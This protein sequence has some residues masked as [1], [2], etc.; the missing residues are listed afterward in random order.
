MVKGMNV[1][2]SRDVGLIDSP[3]CQ[4]KEYKA[5][6]SREFS[7][8]LARGR[9]DEGIRDLVVAINSCSNFFTYTS[10]AG[11][12]HHKSFNEPFLGVGIKYTTLKVDIDRVMDWVRSE[13]EPF[14]LLIL[15]PQELP[16]YRSYIV[17]ESVYEKLFAYFYESNERITQV[18]RYACLELDK[19]GRDFASW[20]FTFCDI[21]KLEGWKRDSETVWEWHACRGRNGSDLSRELLRIRQ[22]W[23]NTFSILVKICETEMRGPTLMV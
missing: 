20:T 3:E 18:D 16:Q 22:E 5:V 1:N 4:F 2:E 6:Y 11:H 15:H 13:C 8:E 12:V 17:G 9:I 21:K 19:I 14:N 23:R 7:E 10:C